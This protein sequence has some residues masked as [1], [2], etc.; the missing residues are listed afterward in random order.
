MPGFEYIDNEEQKNLNK[1]FSE[2]SSILM[3]V[4]FEKLRKRY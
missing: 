1:I 2:N 4:G 3:S